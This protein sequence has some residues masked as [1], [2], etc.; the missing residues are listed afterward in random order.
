MGRVRAASSPMT[1]EWAIDWERPAGDRIDLAHRVLDAL[2]H[3]P[4]VEHAELF[5]SLASH[6]PDGYPADELSDIDVRVTVSRGS[7]RDFFEAVE[8]ILA[9]V[10]KPL[11]KNAFVSDGAY[12]RCV[13]F[14]TYSPFWHVDVVC[15][16]PVH[17]PGADV[18]EAIRPARAFG[19]W[20]SAAKR[21]A[22]AG[23]FLGYFLEAAPYVEATR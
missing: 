23:E 5:G 14:E 8:P 20:L 17:L 7:D 22:R 6:E 10:G 19:A 16:A 12:T 9:R 4:D 13:M 21:F 15:H 1:R 2:H 3:H 11:L 18:L